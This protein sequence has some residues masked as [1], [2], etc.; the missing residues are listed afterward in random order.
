MSSRSPNVEEVA[1]QRGLGTRIDSSTRTIPETVDTSVHTHYLHTAL[2]YV[3]KCVDARLAKFLG[4]KSET[5]I[6]LGRPRSSDATPFANFVRNYEVN[7][8]EVILLILALA[9]HIIPGF[10]DQLVHRHLPNGG[11]LV[12][13][14]GI[15]GK[16]HRGTL[17]TGETALFVLAGIDPVERL[18]CICTFGEEQFL[19]RH[20]IL[21]LEAINSGEPRLS[22]RLLMEVEFVEAF[23]TGKVALPKL[24]MSFP[25]EHISTEMEWDDLVLSE[26]T[27]QHIE[28]IENWIKYH[29]ELLEEWGM[30]RKLKA[31]YRALFY[32]PPGTGKTLTATLLG[33]YTGHHVFRIDLSLVLSKYIGETEK[34]LASLFD[35]AEYKGWILFFDEADAIFGKRVLACAMRMTSMQTRKCLICCNASNL[36]PVCR[37]F[38]RILGIISIKLSSGVSMQ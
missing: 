1:S 32:G 15:K 25:A 18:A 34:N 2:A 6:T 8:D 26:P 37:F 33:K 27:L 23:T 19:F 17:A 10:L 12:E 29:G 38:P 11:E 7:A 14:G 31:G 4:K 24:S 22:G 28:E 21:S 35:K 9:P 5:A 36:T 30:N 16:N 20:K 3:G 13:F